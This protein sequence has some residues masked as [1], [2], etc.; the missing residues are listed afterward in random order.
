MKY[1]YPTFLFSKLLYQL[2]ID[3]LMMGCKCN[4]NNNNY[5]NNNG[6]GKSNHNK[7]HKNVLKR[8]INQQALNNGMIMIMINKFGVQ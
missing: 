7:Y 1:G 6:Y 4:R 3:F 8:I 2:Y 5:N